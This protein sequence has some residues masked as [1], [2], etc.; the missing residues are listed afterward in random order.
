[1]HAGHAGPRL[2]SGQ[3]AATPVTEGN[4]HTKPA[5]R[6]ENDSALVWRI[7]GGMDSVPSLLPMRAPSGLRIRALADPAPLAALTSP[8]H[9]AGGESSGASDLE[10]GL[11]LLRGRVDTALGR[12]GA[13]GRLEKARTRAQREGLLALEATFETELSRVAE[14]G[15]KLD[16]ARSRSER[17]RR[18][19][20]RIGEGLPSALLSLFWRHERRRHL[21]EQSRRFA[22][23]PTAEAGQGIEAHRRLLSLNRRLNSSLSSAPTAV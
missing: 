2:V 22:I 6:R 5:N 16:E 21:L 4:Q 7:G 11:E 8:R 15:Q 1:M 19:W 20:D 9:S 13:F 23:Q 14:R 10:L 12:S 18:L 3:D 17:A